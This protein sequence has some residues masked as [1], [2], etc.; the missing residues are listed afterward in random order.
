MTSLTASPDLDL[1]AQTYVPGANALISPASIRIA[2]AMLARGASGETKEQLDRITAGIDSFESPA[3]GVLKVAN[4][5]WATGGVRDAYVSELARDFAAQ[6]HALGDP[7]GA[8]ERINA[9]VA[10]ATDNLITELL[11]KGD[12]DE[13]T[14][15]ALINA[16]TFKGTWID[17]FDPEATREAAFAAPG[18]AKTAMMM[19]REGRM[20]YE[21]GAGY[22]AVRLDY[23]G[24]YGLHAILPDG[25]DDAPESRRR[26]RGPQMEAGTPAETPDPL[27]ALLAHR[28]SYASERV[29]LS[30]PRFDMRCRSDL[31][32]ALTNL[33][34][35]R[36][37]SAHGELDKIGSDPTLE[38]SKVVHEACM[39]TDE[40][41]TTAAAATAVLVRR[42]S[43]GPRIVR[44]NFNR[45][46]AFKLT[47]G[48]QVLFAG[49]CCDP[50]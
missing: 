25:A 6:A 42:R 37:F 36:M 17:A 5:L 3:D 18:G 44:M 26:T 4:S 23:E 33:G 24:G 29:S 15:L 49:V 16:I 22:S 19:Q 21:R 47:R 43:A 27:Q 48:D 40:K 1:L 39:T 10:E 32:E 50:G 8:A 30:L 11:S 38:V 13:L 31:R 28:G 12:I 34:C 46:F 9:W 20:D 35:G 2:L 45:P 7:S 14:V 41:G